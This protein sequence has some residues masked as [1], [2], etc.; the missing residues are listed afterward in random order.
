M[1][2]SPWVGIKRMLDME[3]FAMFPRAHESMS[4]KE[5]YTHVKEQFSVLLSPSEE[6]GKNILHGLRQ[7]N[8]ELCNNGL[9][10]ALKVL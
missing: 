3:K 2:S 1:T 7:T 8:S 5:W 6:C 10:R 4:Q 9:L